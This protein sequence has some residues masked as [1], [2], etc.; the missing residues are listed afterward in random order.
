MEVKAVVSVWNGAPESAQKTEKL[1]MALVNGERS[2]CSHPPATAGSP[3]PWHCR[4]GSW[5]L[6]TGA[7]AHFPPEEASSGC[8]GKHGNCE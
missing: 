2:G 8:E 4:F 3:E 1:A 5:G 6:R 7:S